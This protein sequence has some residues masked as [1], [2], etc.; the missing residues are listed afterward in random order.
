MFCG[1]ELGGEPLYQRRTE[2]EVG[3][4]LLEADNK[5]KFLLENQYHPGKLD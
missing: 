2:P 3:F 5:R 4:L 1:L